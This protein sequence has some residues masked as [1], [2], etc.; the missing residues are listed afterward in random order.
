[1][2]IADLEAA[3][4]NAAIDE[5]HNRDLAVPS[6]APLLAA[7]QQLVW[8]CDECN[9]DRHTCPGC[10]AS[11]PHMGSGVCAECTEAIESEP[12]ESM[13]A[14]RRHL[15]GQLREIG[16]GTMQEWMRLIDVEDV[17]GIRLQAR[18][19]WQDEDG[20]CLVG[21]TRY[22]EEYGRFRIMVNVQDLGPLPPIGPEN[23]PALAIEQEP[24]EWWPRTWTDVRSGDR[25][26]IP[27]TEHTA[28]VLSAVHLPWHV[29]PKADPYHPERSAVEWTAVRVR[30]EGRTELIDMDPGKLIEIELSAS[31]VAAIEALGWENRIGLITTGGQEK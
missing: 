30:M 25:V 24:L 10:G 31:E 21:S 23:D 9:Y 2:K 4:I 3:V 22:G 1:M 12:H 17:A 18:V 6:L 26:R 29:H 13:Q 28:H 15:A 14:E 16:Q 20:N 8:T 27:D 11:V 19:N 5:L 7:V